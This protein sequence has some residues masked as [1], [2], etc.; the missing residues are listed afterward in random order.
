MHARRFPFFVTLLLVALHAGATDLLKERRW[1]EQLRGGLLS[2]EALT[3]RTDAQPFFAIDTPATTPRT[4]GAAILL[5]GMGAHPDWPEVIH[6]LRLELP[7]SGWRTLS[8]QL[9]VLANE[10]ARD[11]YAALFPDALARIQAAI[12]HLRKQEIDNIVI[13]GHSLGAA[14]GAAFVAQM[15]EGEENPKAFVGIGMPAGSEASLAKITLPV[16]DLYGAQDLDG[17]RASAPLRRQA[18]HKAGNTH[19][20]QDEI[21]GADHFFTGLDATLVS[22]VASWLR[23]QVPTE[24]SR[25][26]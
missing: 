9:P 18:A 14:M 20:R 24:D 4:R 21:P 6:P 22:R 15:G 23:Q 10:A 25:T 17:V 12:D 7:E 2:G 3:L 13:I 26:P 19:Y 5:H 8:I 11:A 1:A 16:L